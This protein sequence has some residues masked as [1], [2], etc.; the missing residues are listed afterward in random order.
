MF[1]GCHPHLKEV[2]IVNASASEVSDDYRE[3]FD[4][5]IKDPDT[6][7][8][9]EIVETSQHPSYNQTSPNCFIKRKAY[10]FNLVLQR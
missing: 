1:V 5:E 3:Y 7:V 9:L 6:N 4:E 2:K 8:T 10:H